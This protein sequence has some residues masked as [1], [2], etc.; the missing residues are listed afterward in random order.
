MITLQE[1]TVCN[2]T[3]GQRILAIGCIAGVY[4]PLG[5]QVKDDGLDVEAVLV[6]PPCRQDRVRVNSNCNL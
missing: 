3:S 2:K 6:F 4:I 5:K 1:Y